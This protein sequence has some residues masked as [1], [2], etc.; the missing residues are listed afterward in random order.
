M[1]SWRTEAERRQP[2][3]SA[4]GNLV[5]FVG[6]VERVITDSEFALCPKTASE[7]DYGI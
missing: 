5:D 2:L 7:T 3:G 6:D 1:K 4:V